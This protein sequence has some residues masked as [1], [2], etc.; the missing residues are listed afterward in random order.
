MRVG[1]HGLY[2]CK[3]GFPTTDPQEVEKFGVTVLYI[4]K[5]EQLRISEGRINS[6]EQ[7]CHGVEI[8]IGTYNVAI[9]SSLELKI[10]IPRE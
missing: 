7:E 6:N 2:E 10:W 9:V 3:A 8:S 5:I 4:D 1:N